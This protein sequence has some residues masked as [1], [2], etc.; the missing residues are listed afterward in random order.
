MK[1]YA[2][3]AFLL[4]ASLGFHA[5]GSSEFI[6]ELEDALKKAYQVNSKWTLSTLQGLDIPASERN[7]TS[8]AEV[9][10]L[11]NIISIFG[12]EF[13]KTLLDH[14][15]P[16]I[17]SKP[18][19]KTVTASHGGASAGA[20][21]IL[22]PGLED[23]L[24]RA[25]RINKDWALGVLRSF[26]VPTAEDSESL[27]HNILF[28]AVDQKSLL[29]SL[30]G[31]I[32]SASPAAPSLWEEGGVYDPTL[33]HEVAPRS[34]LT[35]DEKGVIEA[36]SKAIASIADGTDVHAVN[37]T[38]LVRYAATIQSYMPRLEIPATPG[39]LEEIQK[40]ATAFYD[41]GAGELAN[42]NNVL[43]RINASSTSG[44]LGITAYDALWRAHILAQRC[45]ALRRPGDTTYQSFALK[46]ISQNI[47][48]AGGC[49]DGIVGRAI[50]V[51]IKCLYSLLENFQ[52]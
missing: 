33:G 52:L 29:A 47:E 18:A 41:P 1:L 5:A 17:A 27:K 23:A 34:I 9:A 37:K 42:I 48:E 21:G 43:G 25:I 39:T 30:Q 35:P 32:A 45:D 7:F 46:M 3:I 40:A 19:P 44:E 12:E 6:P 2:F 15:S 24:T 38:I 14:L 28:C 51:Q 36:A 10:A 26:D 31:I 20:G 4:M 22:I 13:Q 50:V 16:I 49:I 11:K 8:T